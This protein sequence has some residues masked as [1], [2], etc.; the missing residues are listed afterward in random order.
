MEDIKYLRKHK[1]E[2]GNASSI[3]TPICLVIDRSKSMTLYKDSFGYTRMD[4]VNEGLQQFIEQLKND[5]ILC[6]SAEIAVVTFVN[7]TD[8][9]TGQLITAK[10]EHEFSTLDNCNFHFTAG[11]GAGD[12]P[13]GVELALN[14]LEKEKQFLKD[15]RKRYNQPWIV[16]MSDGRATPSRLSRNPYTNEKDFSDINY[17]LSQ[18]QGRVKALQ[19]NKKLTVISV[20]ISE[21]NDGQYNDAVRQMRGFTNNG[22]CIEIGSGQ[23]Q[24]SF[25]DFFE[26]LS[27]SVSAGADLFNEDFDIKQDKRYT[28]DDYVAQDQ[29]SKYIKIKK[30]VETV[31]V[32]PVVETPVEE[33]DS[34][35]LLR[36]LQEEAAVEDVIPIEEPKPKPPIVRVEKTRIV[37]AKTVTTTTTNNSDD[38]LAQLLN[39]LDDWDDL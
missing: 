9:A 27:K 1:E 35:K 21:K 10:V 25:K 12:T 39:G 24:I 6:D 28:A 31:V 17:R 13:A 22:K 3:I 19:A 16:I 14:L 37:K 15:N 8:K 33:S 11:N 7:E 23:Q 18:V 4:R 30:P 26:I 32:N 20:L 36:K 38:Y 2:L 5:D 29:V 34:A